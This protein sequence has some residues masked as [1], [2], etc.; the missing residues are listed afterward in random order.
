MTWKTW[1]FGA[2]MFLAGAIIGQTANVSAQTSDEAFN[3]KVKAYIEDRC[4]ANREM[5]QSTPSSSAAYSAQPRRYLNI[6]CR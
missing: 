3:A 2:A 6:E 5:Y 1:T 4:A